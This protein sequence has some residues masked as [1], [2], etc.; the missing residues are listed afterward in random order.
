MHLDRSCSVTLYLIIVGI[1]PTTVGAHRGAW[2]LSSHGANGSFFNLPQRI[3]DHCRRNWP[4]KFWRL[5]HSYKQKDQGS[6]HSIYSFYNKLSNNRFVFSS[7]R[8]R[9]TH[10]YHEAEKKRKEQLVSHIS[11]LLPRSSSTVT[12]KSAIDAIRP[13]P[14]RPCVWHRR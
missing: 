4:M 6:I 14:H 8:I 1:V 3:N 9:R 10:A 13:R 12:A 2:R 5:Q 7:C 11:C